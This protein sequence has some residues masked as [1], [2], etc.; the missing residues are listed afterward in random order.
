L[1]TWDLAF[2]IKGAAQPRRLSLGRLPDVS[3]DSARQRA[4]ELTA[5]GRNGRD[6]IAEERDARKAAAA[7]IS[8]ETLIALYVA[9][10]VAGRLR[11]E[12]EIER[13]LRRALAPLMDRTAE[14]IRRR[15][16]REL[17]EATANQGLER[18]AEKR[19]QVVGAMFRWALAQ[20]I[21]EVDPTSGLSA[22][23]PG[24]P[25]DR[26]LSNDEIATFWRWL[27]ASDI[28][29]GPADILRLQLATGARCGEISGICAEEIDTEAWTW[30]LPASRSK[31]GKPRVTPL[32]GIA[33]DIIDSHLQMTTRGALFV[34][35]SGRAFTSA[36]IG[37]YLL[38]RANHMPIAK[39]T[40]HDLRRTVATALAEM[41]VSFELIAAVIG[42]E[43]GKETRT[44]VRHYVRSNLIDRKKAVLAAWSTQLSKM[45]IG[46]EEASNVVSLR[47]AP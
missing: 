14:D 35:K 11:T 28:P 41:G 40:T 20:D 47:A 13:R 25:R 27:D 10:R 34:A 5:A 8:V 21:V 12:K 45:A 22:Y 36:D 44:L 26:A 30:S 46:G 19:R 1:K 29:N 3:L 6:L 42:H 18:E 9:R 2:R 16:I 31:N 38:A 23:D 39:F 4:N 24:T 7:R 17:L 37:H 33:R 15:D 32:V 43:A